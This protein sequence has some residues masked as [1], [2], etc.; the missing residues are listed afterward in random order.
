M[1]AMERPDLINA[2]LALRSKRVPIDTIEE[3][4]GFANGSD[5]FVMHGT[6]RGARTSLS[7][8]EQGAWRYI[9]DIEGYGFSVRVPY[10]LRSGRVL[11]HVGR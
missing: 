6:K 7:D 9:I 4:I 5:A 3:L 2:S 10:V 1:M 8:W 11:V